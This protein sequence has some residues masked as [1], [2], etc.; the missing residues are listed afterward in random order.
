MFLEKQAAAISHR[1]GPVT[2]GLSVI[3]KRFATAMLRW[4]PIGSLVIE[5]PNGEVFR[6]G[7]V[8]PFEEARLKLNNYRVIAK[9]MTRG[10]IGFA[11]AYMAS[12]IDCPDL[13][14]LIQFFVRNR[15][16]LK[17]TAGRLFGI[18]ARDRVAHRSRRNSRRGSRRNIS[19]HYDLSNEFFRLW[20]DP[21]MIYSS[22]LYARDDQ[23]LEDAQRAKLEAVLCALE[24]SG[25]EEILEIGC[26]WGALA[27]RAVCAHDVRVSGITLSSE[28]LA[29][30]REAADRAGLADRCKF[31]LT[32]YRDVRGEF[33]RIM[34]VEMIEAVGEEYWP[35]FFGQL[36]DRLRPGGIAVVQA[37]TIDERRFNSYRR[38]P[39]FIQRY[40]FPGGMLPTPEIIADQAAAAGLSVEPVTRFGKSYALTLREWRRR[41]DA[42]RPEIA[43]LGFD[44]RF[45]RMWRYYLSYCEAA[46][47]EGAID[48][49]IYRLRKP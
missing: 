1:P 49:A 30:A 8:G 12:D 21:D 45:R 24:L 29:Y 31:S 6:Y 20:L 40:I 22:G 19:A 18:R 48:V 25:G 23:P 5:L 14:S 2:R 46:L 37:I 17:T 42:A 43:R 9:A 10:P 15:D 16:Q 13:K 47:L 28:Q 11:D 7:N 35:S 39:D 26:G 32:D 44:D 41:F 38:K 33:D 34:S 3:V 36:H 27:R 4:E